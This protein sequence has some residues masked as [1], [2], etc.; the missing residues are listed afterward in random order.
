MAFFHSD[1][2]IWYVPFLLAEIEIRDCRI[3]GKS[4]LFLYQ[5]NRNSTARKSIFHYHVVSVSRM[6]YIIHSVVE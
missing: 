6:Q 3:Y 1:G 5:G 4:V 2:T